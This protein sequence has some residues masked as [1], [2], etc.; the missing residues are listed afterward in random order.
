M[1]HGE[2][3]VNHNEIG[4]WTAVRKERYFGDGE[5]QFYESD[6]FKY[7]CHMDYRNGAGYPMEAAFT[8]VHRFG[9]GAVLLASKV[10]LQGMGK[11]KVKPIGRD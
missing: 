8:V 4:R 9:D 2:I 5:D 3:K 11:L 7:E 10:L 1:L 6:Y